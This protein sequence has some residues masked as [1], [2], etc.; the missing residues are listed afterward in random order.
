MILKRKILWRA[1]VGLHGCE[2]CN[3]RDFRQGYNTFSPYCGPGGFWG[4][5]FLIFGLETNP[6]KEE[7]KSSSVLSIYSKYHGG[8]GGGAESATLPPMVKVASRVPVDKC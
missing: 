1:H 7:K 4:P 6:M 5:N 8:G 2:N 3:F